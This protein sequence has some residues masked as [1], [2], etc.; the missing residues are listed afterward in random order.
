MTI[1]N[2]VGCVFEIVFVVKVWLTQG[3][4]VQPKTKSQL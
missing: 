2:A 4:G 3:E 1:F